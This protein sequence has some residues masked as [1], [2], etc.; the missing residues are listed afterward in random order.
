MHKKELLKIKIRH[1][2]NK[3][4]MCQ[5]T[6]KNHILCNFQTENFTTS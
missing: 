5:K 1:F 6:C 2:K 3:N 4:A